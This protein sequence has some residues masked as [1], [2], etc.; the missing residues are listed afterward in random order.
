M[1]GDT[2][3]KGKQAMEAMGLRDANGPIFCRQSAHRQWP[4]P[5]YPQEDFKYPFLLDRMIWVLIR[6][7]NFNVV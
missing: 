4:V 2:D 5:L 1:L 3:H 6:L 7:R